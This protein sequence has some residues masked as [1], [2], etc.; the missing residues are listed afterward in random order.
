MDAIGACVGPQ[1][2]GVNAIVDELRGEKI[3]I[4]K[5][6]EDPAGFMPQRC[7]GGCGQLCSQPTRAKACRVTVP[8]DQLESGHRRRGRTPGLAARLTGYKIDIKA[9]NAE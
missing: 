4:V 9:A 3:D 1:G 7:A 2:A 8:A 5:Y 6:S